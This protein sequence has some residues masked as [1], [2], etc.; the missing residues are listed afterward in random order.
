MENKFICQQAIAKLEEFKLYYKMYIENVKK[1]S[2]IMQPLLSVELKQEI[3]DGILDI[4]EMDATADELISEIEIASSR[5]TAVFNEYWNKLKKRQEDYIDQMTFEFDGVK[6]YRTPLKFSTFA[7]SVGYDVTT[8]TLDI[9]YPTGHIYRYKNIP[10][11]FYN[12]ITIN[13]IEKGLKTEL[14]SY[15]NIKLK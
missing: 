7:I 12:S 15:E 8:N 5:I 10:Q 4:D 14:E 11:D 3:K 13:N 6:I 1:E 2:E 9:E